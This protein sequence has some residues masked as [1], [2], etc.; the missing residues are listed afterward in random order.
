MTLSSPGR[1]GEPRGLPVSPDALSQPIAIAVFGGSD[2]AGRGP[3][4]LHESV[5][6]GRPGWIG[7][8]LGM[9]GTV[10]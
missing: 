3:P 7:T 2:G 10:C 4:R 1:T 6:I 8:A 5:R 9:I